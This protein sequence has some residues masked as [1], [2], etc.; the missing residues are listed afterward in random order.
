MDSIH[1]MPMGWP[2]NYNIYANNVSEEPVS[3][4]DEFLTDFSPI[5][6][7]VIY[8]TEDS[9]VIS[10]ISK[11]QNQSVAV[12]VNTLW[13]ELCGGHY[14]EMALQDPEAHWG[15]VIDHG[16]NII[17]SDRPVLLTKYLRVKGLH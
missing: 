13:P 16:A 6:F 7:E 17:Q 1:Y 5:G 14:D 2:S 10:T 11:M 15:W 9:P 4:V 8:D 3:Y 12:W